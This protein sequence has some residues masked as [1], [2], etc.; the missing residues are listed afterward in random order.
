LQFVD[1]VLIRFSEDEK[2][3]VVKSYEDVL[4]FRSVQMDDSIVLTNSNETIK[5]QINNHDDK[6][7]L[8]VD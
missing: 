8:P 4:Q 1:H 6:S 3:C 5:I 7:Q 2:S